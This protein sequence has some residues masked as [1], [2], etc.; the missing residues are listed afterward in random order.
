[1]AVGSSQNSLISD[2]VA[3]AISHHHRYCLIKLST[4]SI[5]IALHKRIMAC[6][7]WVSISHMVA[8]GGDA[9][10]IWS[11]TTNRLIDLSTDIS[12]SIFGSALVYL[13]VTITR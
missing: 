3:I 8:R 11:S 5:G 9:D 10:N 7:A 4:L 12:L 6:R 2:L 13:F 1:M